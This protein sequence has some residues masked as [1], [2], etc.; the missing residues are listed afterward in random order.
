[1][2]FRAQLHALDSLAPIFR[3]I[4]FPVLLLTQYFHLLQQ[5]DKS[6]PNAMITLSRLEAVQ[7]ACRESGALNKRLS[8]LIQ[9]SHFT[10]LLFRKKRSFLTVPFFLA[11]SRK[12]YIV[13]KEPAYNPALVSSWP[14]LFSCIHDSKM[15]KSSNPNAISVQVAM[16]FIILAIIFAYLSAS[17]SNN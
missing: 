11:F 8:Q 3:K 9:I 5:V 4:R 6:D 16:L 2:I 10:F 17:R 7:K 1:M 14:F 13:K 15:K 12:T